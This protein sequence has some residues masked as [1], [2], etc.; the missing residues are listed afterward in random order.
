MENRSTVLQIAEHY[1]AK[2]VDYN[3]DTIMLRAYGESKKLDNMIS[4]L[5]SFDVREVVRSGKIVMA[6]GV[7]MHCAIAETFLNDGFGG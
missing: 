5:S 7:A 2:V 4:L 6:R 1:K 3:A